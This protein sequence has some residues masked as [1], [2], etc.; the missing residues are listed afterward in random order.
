MKINLRSITTKFLRSTGGSIA[1]LFAGMVLPSIVMCGCAVDLARWQVGSE[2]IHKAADNAVLAGA[3]VLAADKTKT[4]DAVTAANNAFAASISGE[5]II[6]S[7]TIAFA[8]N[9]DGDGVVVSGEAKIKK[10]LSALVPIYE[11]GGVTTA[12]YMTVK[13]TSSSK[14][15]LAGPSANLEVSMVLD[16]TGS[17]CANGQSLSTNAGLPCINDPKMLALKNAAKDLVSKVI[18]ADQAT[19]TSKVAITPFAT[20][21]RVGQNGAAG[22]MTAITGL[23]ATWTGYQN[24]CTAS[25]GG[26]G[27]E[28]AGNWACTTWQSQ[29]KTNWKIMPCVTDRHYNATW[30]YDLT[31]SVAGSGAYLNAHGGDR[32]PK[33]IDS[34]QTAWTTANN[35]TAN[36]AN[37]NGTSSSKAT[38][39]WNY[40]VDGVCADMS[41]SNEIL[42]LTND[43]TTLNSKIDG[44]AAY[45]GT[46]GALGTA[47]GWY[48][49]SPN[50]ASVWPTTSAPKAYSELTALNAA[51]KPKL[52]KIAII[53]SDG[54]YNTYRG[55]KPGSFV[56]ADATVIANAAKAMCTAMKAKGIEIFTVGF[57]LGSLPAAEKTLATDTLKNC[58]TDIAHFYDSLDATALAANFT[59]IGN[60]VANSTA[61]VR[62]VK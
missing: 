3:T 19:F 60:A 23:A 18:W 8:V 42:P 40:S 48:M 35:T 14:F 28:T 32:A 21:V 46:S 33:F 6:A 62:L 9:T 22:Y 43:K 54:G 51:G 12:S 29:S 57:S 25:T 30:T 56:L 59:A 17:M 55:W 13:P 2:V 11:N 24:I 38:K 49:L 37:G 7:N 1:P 27:S 39:Q 44:L 10:G 26:G 52:R 61:D 15:A 4:A 5:T 53:M 47:F 20:S 41:N 34:S 58:G 16:V 31:D 36:G 50:W 45:G